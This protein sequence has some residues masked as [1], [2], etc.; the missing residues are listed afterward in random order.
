MIRTWS[1]ACPLCEAAGSPL[2][3]NDTQDHFVSCPQH[4]EDWK[5]AIGEAINRAAALAPADWWTSPGPQ[6]LQLRTKVAHA[7]AEHLQNDKAHYTHR[8]GFFSAEHA[9]RTIKGVYASEKVEDKPP[10]TTKM[11][12]N[13]RLELVRSASALF[14]KRLVRMEAMGVV[15]KRLV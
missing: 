6:Q 1:T 9:N 7:L 12:K 14:T 10:S 11:F 4:K 15:G 3:H 5:L 13:L 8:C 2:E